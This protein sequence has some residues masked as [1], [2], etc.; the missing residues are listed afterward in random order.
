MTDAR[1]VTLA[2]GGRWWGCY[3]LAFCPAHDNTRTPALSLAQ[4]RGGA[5]L[6]HCHAGCTFYEIVAAL[7]G[8]DMLDARRATEPDPQEIARRQ[9]AE[10]AAAERR[11]RKAQRVWDEA[12]PVRG[13]LAERYLRGRGIRSALPDTLRFHADCWHGPTARRYPAL[14]A[15]VDRPDGFGAVHRTYLTQDGAKADVDD[16]KM[17]LGVCAGGAVRLSDGP[18]PL[19]ACE[20]IET[21]LSL[22]DGL[23]GRC[24]GVWACLGTSGLGGL[25]WP[26]GSRE[27]VIAADGDEPG[28]EAAKALAA[29]AAAAGLHVRIMAA[30]DG[31]DWNDVACEVAA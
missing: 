22:L 31:K 11:V 26:A 16:P 21:G 15:R 5:L 3:G 20:G 27:L 24:G 14:V 12:A 18:G 4:G 13:T 1:T 25:R 29:R 10:R 8:R 7:R 23:R 19:V 30:P 28:R 17:A 6:A 2:L 9:V